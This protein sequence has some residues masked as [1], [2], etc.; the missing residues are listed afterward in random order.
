MSTRDPSPD[1]P[2]PAESFELDASQEAPP[3]PPTPQRRRA[4]TAKRKRAATPKND[5][6]AAASV[7]AAAG[8]RSFVGRAARQIFVAPFTCTCWFYGFSGL[9]TLGLLFLLFNPAFGH[10]HQGVGA[11]KWPWE[12][13][14]DVDGSFAFLWNT[15][16]RFALVL[17]LSSYAFLAASFSPATRGRGLFGLLFCALALPLLSP[18]PTM[19]HSWLIPLACGLTIA[20][21][22]LNRFAP[23]A[24]WPE[25]R[26]FLLVAFLILAILLVFPLAIE[27]DDLGGEPYYTAAGRQAVLPWIEGS[28]IAVKRWENM[29]GSDHWIPTAIGERLIL[30]QSAAIPTAALLIAV[31]ALLVLLGVRAP[32]V[33]WLTGFLM[34]MML[35]G[36]SLMQFLE[37]SM[38]HESEARLAGWELG[39][40]ELALPLRS[41]FLIFFPAAV[42]AI[43]DFRPGSEASDATA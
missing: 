18:D 37:S 33:R 40:V 2:P 22:F 13:F 24:E 25:Q 34:L 15:D 14:K 8:E 28:D 11:G 10:V 35:L 36:P 29:V 17:L 39:L 1:A 4:P 21:L 23:S 42:A 7:E 27:S 43:S 31:L 26:R 6:P 32:F 30:L 20:A 41:S 5:A 38:T 3:P 19:L 16:T 12:L 9:F